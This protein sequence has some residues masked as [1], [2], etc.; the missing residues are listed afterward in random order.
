[1]FTYRVNFGELRKAEVR[2][3]LLP[4]TPVN[5][6]K[7]KGRGY[8]T[9]RPSP[10]LASV[11]LGVSFLALLLSAASSQELVRGPPYRIGDPTYRLRDAAYRITDS[12]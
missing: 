5:K 6:G 8:S 10:L 3:I 4:R 2:R 1:M 12:A 9:P 7:K 11:L